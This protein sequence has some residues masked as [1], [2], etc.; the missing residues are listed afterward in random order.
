MRQNLFIQ[1]VDNKGVF[2][3]ISSKEPGH[4]GRKTEKTINA[5]AFMC[6]GTYLDLG[7][8]L[9]GS[10]TSGRGAIQCKEKPNLHHRQQVVKTRAE[11]KQETRTMR[12]FLC[13]ILNQEP[14]LALRV[15]LSL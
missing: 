11:D 2:W 12:V 1:S 10:A 8:G 3:A 6:P 9:A 4:P 14:F 13:L 5:A 7:H 15:A